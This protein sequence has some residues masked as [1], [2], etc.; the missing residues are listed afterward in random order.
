MM[1]A[2]RFIAPLGALALL[3]CLP[4]SVLAKKLISAYSMRIHI[5]ETH[6]N[7]SSTGYHAFGRA[8]LFD[9]QGV[10]HG[11]EF[12]YDCGDHLM[13]SSGNEAYPAMWKKPGQSVDVVFGEIGANPNSFHDCEFKI[14]E[15]QF[16]FY[17]TQ[18]DLGTE[19]AQEFM[20]RHKNQAPTVGAA[21]P[22]D[23]PV[24]ANPHNNF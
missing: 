20:T 21:T 6:W 4:V 16:V 23:I 19:S 24:S 10:P 14:A 2:S 13:A 18:G 3:L 7:H 17:H 12:T 11:V 1:K 15:K 5:Y 8:N 9:E 22:A